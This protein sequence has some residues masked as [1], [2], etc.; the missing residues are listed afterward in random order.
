MEVRMETEDIYIEDAKK[1]SKT[2]TYK[3]ETNKI[4]RK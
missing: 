4:W 1:S 3:N 2:R